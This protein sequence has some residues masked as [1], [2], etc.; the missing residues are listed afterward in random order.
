MPALT[1]TDDPKNRLLTA[2]GQI[3]AEKGF[4]GATIR[5]IKDLAGLN[6]AAV[7]Y[8]YGDKERLYI[9]AVKFALWDCIKGMQISRWPEGTSAKDKL[10]YFIRIFVTHLLNPDRPRWHIQLIMRELAKP[11]AAC[12]EVVRDYIKPVSQA[13][14]EILNDLVP[15]EMPTWKR[16][17]IAFSIIGQCIYYA[18]NRPV[19]E[20]L[21]GPEEFKEFDCERIADHVTQFT[22]AAMGLMQPICHA[23]DIPWVGLHSKC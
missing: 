6:V 2:A 10:Q 22:L 8:Y 20:L 11:T 5:K 12:F 18:Q 9:E 4:R 23:G 3:F 15:A 16:F 13:L 17:M 19:A 14:Q 21:V 7:N 1:N